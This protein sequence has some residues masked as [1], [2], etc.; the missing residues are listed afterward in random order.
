MPQGE[1]SDVGYNYEYEK[2]D[3]AL[4]TNETGEKT[5]LA[6]QEAA[7]ALAHTY[8][9]TLTDAQESQ[10]LKS[11]YYK[12]IATPTE[13]EGTYTMSV[14]LDKAEV[15]VDLG[16]SDEDVDA[17]VTVTDTTPTFYLKNSV[18]KG[19]YYSVGTITDPTAENP[20]VTVLAEKQ[21]TADGQEISLEVSP[22]NFSDGDV[23][24]YK[25]SVS[26]SAQKTP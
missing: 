16:K 5:G 21:A 11:S 25:L 4:L 19:L 12:V 23:I 18:K 17:P 6:D 15:G 20:T 13:T 26:D 3:D 22:M 24:Y 14:V 2:G 10:G 9:V 7:D 1:A 8:N